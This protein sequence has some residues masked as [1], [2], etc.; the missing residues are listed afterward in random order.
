MLAVPPDEVAGVRSICARREG[1]EATVIG[2]F[3]PTG[4]LQLK[5]QR[6]VGRPTW[7][8]SSCTTAGRRWCARRRYAAAGR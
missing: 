2:K 3:V 6:A 7:R 5:Y 8:W 4:R 1:V